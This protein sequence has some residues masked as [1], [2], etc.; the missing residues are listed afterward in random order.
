MNAFRQA[1]DVA[2]GEPHDGQAGTPV[3]SQQPRLL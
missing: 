1:Q 3:G 2:Q